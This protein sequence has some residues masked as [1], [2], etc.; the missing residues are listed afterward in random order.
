VLDDV[1][2]GFISVA[3]ARRDFGVVH[4][5]DMMIDTD[6]TAAARGAHPGLPGA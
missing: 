5:P 3:P 4:T 6:A 1:L 2:D